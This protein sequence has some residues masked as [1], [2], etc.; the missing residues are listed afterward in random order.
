MPKN[1]IS[2]QEGAEAYAE[3]CC[4]LGLLHHQYTAVESELNT[5]VLAAVTRLSKMRRAAPLIAVLGGQRMG[6]VKDTIKRLMRATRASERRKAYV[7]ALFLQLG[8][9]QFFRDRL[10]HHQ[11]VMSE[12]DPD[13]WVNMNFAGIRELHQM[14]DIYFRIDA[15][16][17]AANDLVAIRAAAGDLFNHYLRRGSSRTPPLPLWQYKPSMLTRDRPIPSGKR[18]QAKRSP[19]PSRWNG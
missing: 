2:Y 6:P 1:P 13:V 17:A 18:S 12:D 11:T 8:E 7:D 3:F 16:H 9:I 14:E 19:K 15:L 10:A 4:G 5:A